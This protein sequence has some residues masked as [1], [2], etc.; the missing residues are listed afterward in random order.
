MQQEVKLPRLLSLADLEQAIEVQ[1]TAFQ[2]DPLWQYL[3]PDTEKRTKLLFKFFRVLIS[4]GI[5]AGQAYGVGEPLEGFAVWSIPNQKGLSLIGFIKAG[6]LKLLFSPFILLFFKAF[7]VFAKFETMQKK[8]ALE[9]HYYLN[10]ISVKPSAQGK[11]IA[12]KLIKPFLEMADNEKVG[13]YTETV[14]PENVSL[15]E[16]YGFKCVEQYRVPKTNL[17]VW[18]F[19]RPA[20]KD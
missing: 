6:F 10:T 3:V 12:S 13:V 14:T 15:Y 18:A 19:Y 1:A 7:K 9:P 5:L 11:G 8:Y 2:N 20:K 16:Y 17:S 4:S